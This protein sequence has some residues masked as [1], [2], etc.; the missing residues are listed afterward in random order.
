VAQ[1]KESMYTARICEESELKE[2]LWEREGCT[3]VL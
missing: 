1:P 3:T 2:G